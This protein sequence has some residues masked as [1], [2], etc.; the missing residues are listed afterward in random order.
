MKVIASNEVTKYIKDGDMVAISG[1]GG[2]GSCEAVIKAIKDAF[3]TTA[4]PCYL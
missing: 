1:S 3:L 4:H 2:S